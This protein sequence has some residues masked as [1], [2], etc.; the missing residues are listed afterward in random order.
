MKTLMGLT[1]AQL[2]E[3][4]DAELPADAYSPVP[5]GAD[6]TDIDPNVRHEAV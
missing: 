1:L 2:Q 5:G 6:L 4:L 3:R